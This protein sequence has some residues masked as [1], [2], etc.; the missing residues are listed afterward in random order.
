MT[1]IALATAAATS[2]EPATAAALAARSWDWAIFI[3]VY[4][5]VAI[6]TLPFTRLNRSAIALLGAIALI[7]AGRL[8]FPQ[9]TDQIDWRTLALL[10][11]LMLVAANLR[12]AGFYDKVIAQIVAHANRPLVLVSSV[13]LA[14]ALFSAIFANDIVC[15]AFAPVLCQAILRAGRDPLPY[16]ITLATAS[17]IGSAATIIG[18]PQNMLIGQTAH[19]SFPHF[20]L[21]VSPL[22][23]LCLALN[24]LIVT[25]VYRSRLFAPAGR[26]RI[27]HDEPPARFRPWHV[28]KT[29]LIMAA[30]M[31]VFLFT[32]VPREV[33]ALVAAALVLISRTQDPRKL[34][35]LVDWE[36]ILLFIGLF[37]VI[38]NVQQHGLLSGFMRGLQ[39]R[40]FPLY[41]L[42][43]FTL[44]TAALSNIVSNVPAVL[45]LKP[46]LPLPASPADP[47]THTWYLLAVASTFA[48]NLTLL[49]SIANLIVAEQAKKKGVLVSFAD[50][51]KAGIP[52]TLATLALTIAWFWFL[53]T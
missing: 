17:N 9:A 6:G 8:S 34:F 12:V 2:T 18:N 25:L 16:L 26:P 40:Q 47:I 20:F 11:A 31:A 4:I 52:L 37:V 35:A 43:P 53:G 41:S 19:L 30:L 24:I 1:P 36:L 45:L 48:G 39:R 28:A 38:G 32:G 13:A 49:G 33:A 14:A 44:I 10:F 29:L 7:A 51:L 42:F 23:L 21:A 3:I 22:V 50:Y 46:G 15:L 5:G 27:D